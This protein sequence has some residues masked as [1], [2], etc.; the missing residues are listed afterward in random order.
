MLGLIY[1]NW[2]KYFSASFKYIESMQSIVSQVECKDLSGYK[3]AASFSGFSTSSAVKA[4]ASSSKV[5]LNNPPSSA[6]CSQYDD[7]YEGISS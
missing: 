4:G 2:G 3:M 5:K 1:A 7:C 6:C